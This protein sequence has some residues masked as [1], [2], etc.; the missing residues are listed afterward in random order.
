MT[1][2]ISSNKQTTT[3]NK[4]TNMSDMDVEIGLVCTPTK[5]SSILSTVRNGYDSIEV[6]YDHPI[7][8]F[9]TMAEAAP[10]RFVSKEYEDAISVTPFKHVGSRKSDD[11]SEICI[12]PKKFRKWRES[13]PCA[14]TFG[15]F[16]CA[17]N[18]KSYINLTTNILTR[19]LP[20]MPRLQS[21]QF[22]RFEDV[23]ENISKLIPV[24]PT[25]TMLNEVCFA[26]YSD[27][28][29]ILSILK[30]LPKSIKILDISGSNICAGGTD[31]LVDCLSRFT[32]LNSLHMHNCSI[33]P[34]DLKKILAAL[35][36]TITFLDFN[37]NKIGNE[38]TLVFAEQLHRFENLDKIS[39]YKN[40]ITEKGQKVLYPAVAKYPKLKLLLTP[41][42]FK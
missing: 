14:A 15:K 9:F 29:D 38:G 27:T 40:G 12:K 6:E 2:I 13:F 32:E 18:K 19:V 24:I 20:L 34:S 16:Y 41:T 28:P 25:L 31:G 11:E 17:S 21:I 8:R 5:D 7:F 4:L 3:N 37:F 36:E 26:W 35:P 39:L 23:T 1:N 33:T 42:D 22:P 30:V 10:M